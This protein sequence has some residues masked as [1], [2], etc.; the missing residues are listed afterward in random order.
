M[1]TALLEQPDV[2]IQDQIDYLAAGI[3]DRT[4][5]PER[6][7]GRTMTREQR[8][9]GAAGARWRQLPRRVFY[10]TWRLLPGWAQGLAFRLA[11]PKVS[12]GAVAVIQ[13]VRGRIL[14]AHH[15]YRQ[16]PWGLP[17]GLVGRGEQPAEAVERE[18]REE[19][20]V[21]AVVGPLLYAETCLPTNHLTL[22]YLAMID[23]QP[24]QDGVEIDGFSYVALNEAALLLGE[25]A[26]PWLTSLQ[27][28]MAR[29]HIWAS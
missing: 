16:R 13:D 18:L 2:E 9:R 3:L 20:G 4:V 26:K 15:T 23:G 5:A 25:E 10:G 1:K 6:D 19:L 28:M 7:A 24:H 29:S 14:L 21:A 12:M 11:A 22:Y 27:Q 8:E 17:G